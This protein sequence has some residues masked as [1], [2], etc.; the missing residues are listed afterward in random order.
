L[1]LVEKFDAMCAAVLPDEFFKAISHT[2][3][4]L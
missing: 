1:D 2:M 4:K 3:L